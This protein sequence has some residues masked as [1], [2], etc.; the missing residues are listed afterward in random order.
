MQT[1]TAAQ[2]RALALIGQAPPLG[3]E[4]V[5]LWSSG[6]CRLRVK[7]PQGAPR[8]MPATYEWLKDQELITEA[9]YGRP[10]TTGKERNQRYATL[11]NVGRAVLADSQTDRKGA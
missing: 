7:T 2:H 1:L 11:T 8:I 6:W 4:V 9:R 5:D 10:S 3:L